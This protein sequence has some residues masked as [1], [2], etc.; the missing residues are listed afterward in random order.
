MRLAFTA[1]VEVIQERTALKLFRKPEIH[2]MHRGELPNNCWYGQSLRLLH[3]NDTEN[4]LRSQ[5]PLTYPVTC[6]QSIGVA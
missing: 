2:H 3:A 1:I 6:S 4:S 5:P